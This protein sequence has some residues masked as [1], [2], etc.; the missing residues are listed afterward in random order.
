MGACRVK[1]D[2]RGL[3]AH[4]AGMPIDELHPLLLASASPRRRELLERI[5]I[6]LRVRP[7]QVDET[8][9][10]GEG[11]AAYLERIVAAKLMGARRGGLGDC[12]A[13]LVADTVVVLSDRI[14]GKPRDDDEA[15]DM[16]M[17]L[18]GTSHAVMTRYA[19]WWP[20]AASDGRAQTVAT[21]VW[22]RPLSKDDVHAYVATG[23]GRDKA[24]AY[25]IQGIG[26][27]LVDRIEGSYTN[28]VGLPLSDVVATFQRAQL[29]AA[30]P[31]GAADLSP[32][33]DGTDS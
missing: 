25:A 17:D 12:A 10:D 2:E 15:C 27:A 5:G 16:L 31:P 3:V 32:A 23:E 29:L 7:V 11:A 9:A 33:D 18:A 14:L 4:H 8:V 30:C 22:F 20:S 28:V 13:T 6:P 1:L 24:G 19:A 21:R 26:A